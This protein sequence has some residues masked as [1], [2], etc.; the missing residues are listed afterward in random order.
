MEQTEAKKQAECFLW[1]WNTHKKTRRIIYHV[2]NGGQRNPIEAMKFKSMGVIA[3][4]PDL[5]L[6]TA[7]TINKI[8]YHSLY[9]EMKTDSGKESDEQIKVHAALRAAGNYVVTIR[10]LEAFKKIIFEYLDGTGYID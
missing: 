5:H 4:I 1:L 6:A 9:I 7:G 8:K 2:P 10:T 3:G